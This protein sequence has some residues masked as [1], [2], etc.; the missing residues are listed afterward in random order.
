MVAEDDDPA[1]AGSESLRMYVVRHGDTLSN[2]AAREL[3][4]ISLADNI[5][6]LN[7][8][9]I[10]D[11]DSLTVGVKIRLPVRDGFIPDAATVTQPG[12]ARRP[13]QGIGRT[14]IVARG[15][16]LSSIALEYY[17]ASSGWRFLYEANKTIV[18]NPNQL[19]VGTELTIPPYEDN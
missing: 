5:F 17:G 6:L 10:E 9:V 14:H 18:P 16:T 8:D 19:S 7:R 4:S 3:G 2:I 12:P 1:A 15:D 13:N 11:P